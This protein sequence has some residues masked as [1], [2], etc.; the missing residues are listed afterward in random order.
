MP[1]AIDNRSTSIT[2]RAL[3]ATAA[4]AAPLAA[5]MTGAPAVAGTFSAHPDAALLAAWAG[6]VRAHRDLDQVI[7]VLPDGGTDEDHKPYYDAIDFYSSQ[8]EHIPASTVDGFAVQLRYLFAVRKECIASFDAAVR[9]EP[10]TNE[11]AAELE[12]DHRDKMLWGMVQ[13]ANAL[14]TI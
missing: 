7:E 8:I 14:A 1:E 2:R 13:A 5:L 12:L 3:L 9:G 4:V 11:L 10:L 6:Y